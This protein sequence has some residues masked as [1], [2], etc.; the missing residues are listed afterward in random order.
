MI[1]K[2]IWQTYKTDYKNLPQKAKEC[3][4]SWKN[5]NPEYEYRYLNDN[6]I[7]EFTEK[8]Y[9]KE[10][11]ELMQ[12]F[13]V[14]VMKA[15]LWRILVIYE[16]GGVYA[17]IDTRIFIPLDS[18]IINDGIH[19]EGIEINI[20]NNDFIIAIEN[21]LHYA[22]WVYMAKAKSPI[23]KSILDIILERC[24]NIDYQM[25]EFVHYYTGPDAFTEGIRRYFDLPSLK[26]ECISM[27]E[28]N[29]CLCELLQN[30]SLNY[31]LNEKMKNEKFFCYSG[32]EWDSFKKKII[33]HSFGSYHWREDSDYQSWIKHPLVNRK[34]D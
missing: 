1:P 17:D 7:Y 27:I 12:S 20:M 14:P 16:F 15:D 22:Q 30:E 11:L 31:N 28:K 5:L 33:E 2:I 25:T 26:H 4:D 23:I 24:K 18:L 6:E 19:R 34:I 10:M 21:G 29:N 3:S 9:G 8:Y 13:K 32:N